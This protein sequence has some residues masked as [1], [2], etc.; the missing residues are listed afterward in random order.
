MRDPE[1]IDRVLNSIREAW[2]ETPDWRLG[3]LLVNAI[4]PSEPCPEIFYIEDSK[5]ERLVT[6][7]NITTGNQMQTPS[8]K[9]E[10][11]R[12]YIWDDGLGPIWPIVDNEKT[13]FATAL[14]IYW[15]M[16]GPWFKGSLSDDAKRLHD[17][18][19]ERLL[20]GFYSNR[21]LQ[22][23]PIEDNQ[24]SKTQVYKLRKSGLPSELFEPD[25][26]VSGE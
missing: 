9:H 17:T 10:W 6:R 3:Q 26:P 16:E 12:Q 20:G 13:E 1:R 15:R 14:M 23:F 19:A 4:K 8:Q 25:Y 18:V 5:L 2:I 22:Y 7:L 24:L 11:V 21:N